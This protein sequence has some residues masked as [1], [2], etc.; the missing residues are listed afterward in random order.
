M[1]DGERNRALTIVKSRG[2]GHSNQVR[3]LTLADDGVTLTDV[4][5][6]QGKVLMGVAR[7]EWEQEEQA[8]KQRTEV[9]AEL[10]RLQ[11]QLAQAEAAARLQVVKTEM[12][13]RNAEIA[14]LAQATGSASRLLVTDKEVLRKMRHGDEEVGDA[15]RTGAKRA[16]SR[17]RGVN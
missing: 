12:E 1:Q 8:E 15:K 3:E 14:V 5:V 11:L 2:T 13:A 4:F 17:Q 9:S 6:A 10:K 7:W 16:A